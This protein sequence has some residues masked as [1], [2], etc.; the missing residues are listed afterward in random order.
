[1]AIIEQEWL[2]PPDVSAPAPDNR[3]NQVKYWI[4]DRWIRD[5]FSNF[6]RTPIFQTW[7]HVVGQL[8][9]INNISKLA[10]ANPTPSLTTL[11]DAF[12]CFRGL[13]RPHD[14][15]LDGG[16]VVVY[17]L[18]PSI[19]IDYE[20]DMV[21]QAKARIIQPNLVLTVQVRLPGRRTRGR[22][23]VGAGR[24]W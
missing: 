2:R 13:E 24:R 20:S 6:R 21:C 23:P 7:A 18:R 4:S 11:N 19:S 16:S 22:H 15:E 3:Q 10:D 5:C 14:E 17:V 12:A 9:P 1:M 8:P